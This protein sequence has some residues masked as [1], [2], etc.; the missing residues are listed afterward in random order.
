V[1]KAGLPLGCALAAVSGC[2]LYTDTINQAPTVKL[3][4]P[5]AV[6]PRSPATF[7]AEAQDPDGD[8]VQL[9]WSTLPGGCAS[10]SASAWAAAGEQNGFAFMVTPGSRDRFCVRVVARDDSGAEA[11]A[12]VDVE[13]ENR[14]PVARLAL[15]PA[16]APGALVPIFSTVK[17]DA[18]GSDDPDGDDVLRTFEVKDAAGMAIML[19]ECGSTTRCFV[20]ERSGAY[21]ATLAVS[22]GALTQTATVVFNVAEDQPPC[23]EQTDPA[24]AIPVVVLPADGPSRRFEV[25]QV[26]D[27]G[28]PFP[29]G[30]RG[31]ASFHWFAGRGEAGA[32]VRI[33]GHDRPELDVGANLIDDVRPGDVARVRVEV[34]D[35]E[36]EKPSELRALDA[37][38][39]RAVCEQP[40]GCVRWITWTLRF[41]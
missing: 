27:D 35:P 15:R 39:D 41:Q 16:T 22:D 36:R 11:Q 1:G 21:V 23:I 2:L 40:A 25:K 17:L 7:R 26:R 12:V 20:A 24:V 32:L 28:H 19:D 30:P 33:V 31:R 8:Q 3:L 18:T 34:R 37:C 13:P 29:A 9:G 5:A 6:H 14:V 4:P 10:I 38:A